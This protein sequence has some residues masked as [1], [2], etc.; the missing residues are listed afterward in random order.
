MKQ[1]ISVGALLAS[2]VASHNGYALPDDINQ[3]LEIQ[4]DEAMFDQNSGEAIYKG[5]VFV[6]QGTIEIQ[7]QYLR[8]S[9]NPQT[10]QFSSL[11]AKGEPAIFSQQI[12]WSGNMVI[13][14]G[15]EIQY[16]TDESKLEITGNGYI[17]R[18]QNAITADYI[19]YN[20]TSGTFTA[21]RKGSGRVM[22]TLQP[23]LQEAER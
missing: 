17:S 21:E 3:P 9:S 2:F 14:K 5:N 20:I 1:L 10:R 23:Q 6:K 18:M 8:V 11:Q 19:Q 4:A 7:A 22:M 12:D 13:S 16:L 15:N